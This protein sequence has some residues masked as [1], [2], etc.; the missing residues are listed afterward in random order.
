VY[1]AF[2]FIHAADIHLDSPLHGLPAHY[3]GATAAIRDAP[4]NAFERLV[5]TAIDR[6]VAFLVIAG[7][8]YDGSQRDINT[9][10]FFGQQ[11]AR[12]NERNIQA[13]VLFGNHDFESLIT[14]QLPRSNNLHLFSSNEPQTFAID[15]LGVS[16]HG[17]SFPRRDVNTNLASRYPAPVAGHF[18]IGVLHTALSGREPHGAYAP[19]SAEQL[20]D[21]GYHYWALGHVHQHEVVV[22]NPPVI[23]PGNIQG[24]HIGETGPKGA[25]LVQVAADG[26]VSAER[27]ILDSVRWH[28]VEVDLTDVDLRNEVIG[29][30]ADAIAS[31]I[32]QSEQLQSDHLHAIRVELTGVTRLHGDLLWWAQD[33]D[34]D[35]LTATSGTGAQVWIERV[36][37]RTQPPP[38]PKETLSDELR[39][40]IDRVLQ[41]PETLEAIFEDQANLR[42]T[43]PGEVFAVLKDERRLGGDN[44]G[45]VRALAREGAELALARLTGGNS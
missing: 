45:S 31:A 12:L 7:D 39:G 22:E 28:R 23:F 43:V 26:R 18:N 20:R 33:L 10:V 13:Y 27:L 29:H 5:T 38:E 21:H 9:A 37:L 6:R 1:R 42:G 11:M 40:L 41:D 17:Q 34:A 8:L 35:I 24:R 30:C 4:R 25:V 2:S 14:R 32:Q 3:Q 44:A 15:E 16:L 36:E 19:C